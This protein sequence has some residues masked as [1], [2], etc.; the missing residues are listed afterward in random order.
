MAV[1]LPQ[2]GALE[3]LQPEV[4]QLIRVAQH[5]PLLQPPLLLAGQLGA[6]LKDEV[7]Q[8]PDGSPQRPAVKTSPPVP[9][10][11]Q[12]VPLSVPGVG[13]MLLFL[14]MVAVGALSRVGGRLLRGPCKEKGPSGPEAQAR[15]R[16]A[17]VG[18][19]VL[20][21]LP[22][23]VAVPLLLPVPVWLPTLLWVLPLLPLGPLPVRLLP[24]LLA[25]GPF[26]VAAW[27]PALPSP[28]A[29]DVEPW[30]CVDQCH[31]AVLLVPHQLGLPVGFVLAVVATLP[32][33][34]PLRPLLAVRTYP[35]GLGLVPTLLPVRSTMVPRVPLPLL[36][37][38]VGLRLLEPLAVPPIA[39]EL[40]NRGMHVYPGTTVQANLEQRL[41][42]V[43]H[44]RP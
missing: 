10:H 8:Y 12:E 3:E 4:G 24:L 31:R 18:E 38:P 40:P 42:L 30:Q 20:G 13:V 28:S 29:K 35:L 6:G 21:V 33:L 7:L 22:S 16:G 14:P 5:A 43:Q 19:G 17:C 37:L 15:P 32:Q 44:C 34:A 41:G 1:P 27:A 26:L 36:L 2:L 39:A 9:F 23:L 11:V 25:A